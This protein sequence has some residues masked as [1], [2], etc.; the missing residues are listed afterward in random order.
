MVAAPRRVCHQS[1]FGQ[2]FWRCSQRPT[3]RSRDL[4]NRGDWS[5]RL[6][7]PTFCLGALT[8]PL[9]GSALNGWQSFTLPIEEASDGEWRSWHEMSLLFKT[10]PKTCFG[11][12]VVGILVIH[13]LSFSFRIQSAQ[14]D[15]DSA[16]PCLNREKV[17]R[18]ASS[19]AHECLLFLSS[20]VL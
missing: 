10:S 20:I 19:L 12:I 3:D 13:H 1:T 11:G 8:E 15:S 2:N 18:V 7:R 6:D 5:K 9:T 14:H 4:P 17:S 16:S